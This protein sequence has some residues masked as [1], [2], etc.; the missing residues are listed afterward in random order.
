MKIIVS[1]PPP[2][3][4]ELIEILKQEFSD[5]YNYKLFGIGKEK[6]IIVQKST[7]VGAQISKTGNEF[8]IEGIHPSVTA[9]LTAL[10]L[11]V[12][13]NL[14]ILFQPSP[15]REL[16]KKVAIFLKHKYK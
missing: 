8:L 7:F 11:Q 1:K 15:Y 9:S 10:L 5:R 2:P 3:N 13:A 6:N 14:F 4:N 12:L 16:E